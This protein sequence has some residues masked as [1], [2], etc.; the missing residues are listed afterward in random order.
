[1][2]TERLDWIG[3][4]LRLWPSRRERRF[5]A[6]NKRV[7]S[8][9]ASVWRANLSSSPCYAPLN[10]TICCIDRHPSERYRWMDAQRFDRLLRSLSMTPSR[11]G[12]LGLLAGSALAGLLGF[13]QQTTTAKGKGKGKRK[14]KRKKC[15]DSSQITICHQGQTLSVSN[16]ALPAHL[17]HGDTEGA[18]PSPSFTEIACPG[19]NEGGVSGTG[20]V[21]Q[22]F[23]ANGNGAIATAKVEIGGASAGDDFVF[24]IRSVDQNGVPTSNVLGTSQVNDVAAIATP[25]FVTATFTPPVP[26]TFNTTYALVVSKTGGGPL[27]DRR[28]GDDCA[29]TFFN[30]PGAINA[31]VPNASTDLIFTVSP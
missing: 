11:R 28:T 27:F 26:V 2:A 29:G 14:G 6:R 17:A 12:A 16:C 13:E 30:D 25:T 1:M 23:V 8:R 19:P 9:S 15:V 21:A 31:F 10:V 18:C 4:A 22:T 20:R 3:N 24:E 5:L 7:G